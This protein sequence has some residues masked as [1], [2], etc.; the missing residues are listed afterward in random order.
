LPEAS[1]MKS[2]GTA[3]AADRKD[4]PRFRTISASGRSRHLTAGWSDAYLHHSQKSR[5]RK[6]SAQLGRSDQLSI[7]NTDPFPNTDP[8]ALQP[9]GRSDTSHGAGRLKTLIGSSSTQIVVRHPRESFG[10]RFCCR[11]LR[12]NLQ[13]PHGGHP[14]YT[15]RLRGRYIIQDLLVLTCPAAS[16]SIPQTSSEQL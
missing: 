2:R 1:G 5:S 7:P 14:R 4:E 10:S 3:L 12:R 8:L 9:P 6:S 16:A 15:A 13:T 11:L